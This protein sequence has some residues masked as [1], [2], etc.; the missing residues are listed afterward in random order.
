[1][2]TELSVWSSYYI[3]LSPEDAILEFKKHGIFYTELSDEHSLELLKRGDASVVGSK[4]RSFI[5]REGFCIPQGHLW[6]RCQICTVDD[7]VDI[8]KKW[9][10][11]YV[12]IGIKN[13]VLHVDNMKND[14]SLTNDEK[15]AMNIDKLKQI[16]KYILDNNLDI[17][18]C[19]ENLGGIVADADG[20]NYLIDNLDSRCFGICLDTG[21][22]NLHDKDQK[23]FILKAGKRLKALHI[24]DNEG[25]KDQHM[26]P[27][28][29]G[30][31]DFAEV[32]NALETVE[33]SGL[34]NLEIPGERNAPLEIRGYKL[35]YIKK[36]YQFMVDKNK[37]Y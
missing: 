5:Q 19:L 10:D 11:L 31:I 18:I 24:A 34:F 32:I 35:E 23:S 12:A 29:R 25:L 20:L 17:C 16:Q 13:A 15:R 9:L 3:D 8:L 27:Y 21:H 4:F 30:N 33:Y 37:K 22:L 26:M 1:M 28:G 6:L 2:N 7:A 14:N 36:C